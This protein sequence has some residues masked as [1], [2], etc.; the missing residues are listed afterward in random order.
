ME[1]NTN[2]M[3]INSQRSMGVK[4][5][6]KSELAEKLSSGLRI[7]RAGDDAAGLAISE[8]MRNQIKG[9]QQASRNAEDGISLIQTTEG[10]LSE[11]YEML[12]RVREMSIQSINDTYTNE[13]RKK[14]DIEAQQLILSIDDLANK[15]EFNEQK[16]LTGDPTGK[17]LA[18][19][20]AQ[21]QNL[22][23][24]LKTY[25]AHIGAHDSLL[26]MSYSV[27]TALPLQTALQSA[28]DLEY[29]IEALEIQAQGENSDIK[30]DVLTKISHF[31][32]SFEQ[33]Y[34]S[35]SQYE[36]QANSLRSAAISFATMA[37]SVEADMVAFVSKTLQAT[38]NEKVGPNEFTFQ[39]GPNNDQE[40]H[41][42]IKA[43]NSTALGLDATK[44]DT[45]ES[46]K[47]ALTSVDA[48]VEIISRQKALLG[49]VQNRLE[50]TVKS[51]NISAENLQAAESQIRDADMAQEMM[52]LTKTN[53]ISQASQSILV[54]AN[55]VPQ[56]VLQLL[57]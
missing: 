32:V 33:L 44:L 15:A 45:P 27:T 26:G 48:A 1:I 3:A 56:Q 18:S 12:T 38:M 39:V 50:H 22:A 23:A 9:F 31:R 55:Q 21:K 5:E 10:A 11:I 20:A 54:Q 49:A 29:K 6:E 14:L 51:V 7:N 2:L 34:S 52:N 57:Q 36:A 4:Q 37:V 24:A 25:Y 42:N 46:A 17:G 43:M 13:D 41:L 47:L 16:I 28:I 40:I 19:V 53:I 35:I 8:K 30:Q